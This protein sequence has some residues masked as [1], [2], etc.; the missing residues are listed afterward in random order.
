MDIFEKTVIGKMGVLGMRWGE[1][2]PKSTT[3]Y[4]LSWN[5]IGKKIPKDYDKLVIPEIEKVLSHIQGDVI[6]NKV[7]NYILYEFN[8]DKTKGVLNSINIRSFDGKTKKIYYEIN[9]KE[10]KIKLINESEES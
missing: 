5:N 4:S 7:Y 6:K 8:K 2:K 10:I 9:D 1:H 3:E